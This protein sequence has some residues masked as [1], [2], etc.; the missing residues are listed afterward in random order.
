M[1]VEPDQTRSQRD[2]DAGP[3]IG[4][5][6][7][8]RHTQQ[9]LER[10]AAELDLRYGP[11]R[12][13]AMNA[14]QAVQRVGGGAIRWTAVPIAGVRKLGL[15]DT[16]VGM[17]VDQTRYLAELGTSGQE[18]ASR[19]NMGAGF[20]LLAI[21]VSPRGCRYRT[22]TE[23]AE[24]GVEVVFEVDPDEGPGLRTLR[25]GPEGWWA[26]VS[27]EKAP[28]EIRE[29]G[30]GTEVVLMGHADDAD[31]AAPPSD[32]DPSS[33]LRR[34]L[35]GR[36]FRLPDGIQMTIAAPLEADGD[37]QAQ[38]LAASKPDLVVDGQEA[39]LDAWCVERGS[40]PLRHARAHWWVLNDRVRAR[41]GQAAHH[42]TSGHV[43]SL[44]QDELYDVVTLGRGGTDRLGRFGVRAGAERVV[45]YVE[46]DEQLVLPNTARTRLLLDP[47]RPENVGRASWKAE[48]E[49]P[50]E[51]W[52]EEFAQKL[53]TAIADLQRAA[54][55][56]PLDA[57]TLRA[58]LAREL[59]GATRLRRISTF[60]T[61]APSAPS[62]RSTSR[63][64][65][66][67]PRAA[68][69]PPVGED[70]IVPVGR[71]RVAPTG[72]EW[73]RRLLP[74]PAPERPAP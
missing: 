73:A 1:T 71:R 37:I 35:N 72:E 2:G 15:V 59:A 41:R 50:W 8:V 22:Y 48:R 67:S 40:V 4:L 33:W 62:S 14:I 43:A 23:G 63:A 30:H 21:A 38:V 42:L 53:P 17:T 19:G 44:F 51:D 45:I 56:G 32:T 6:V 64:A 36:L 5:R 13:L 26:P 29:A 16:G 69:G 12:E 7:T 65:S 25:P 47:Q 58:E 49:L 10:Q 57:H 11:P 3:T 27:W 24:H 31:T 20:K 61:T 55:A 54:T 74:A 39:W 18:L 46:P 66:S 28:R 34:A 9:L 70:G 52:A 68:D 60:R